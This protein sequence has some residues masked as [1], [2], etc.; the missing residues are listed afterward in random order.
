MPR[1]NLLIKKYYPLFLIFFGFLLMSFAAG[2]RLYNQRIL[3]FSSVPSQVEAKNLEKNIP[4][5]ITI[6]KVAIDVVVEV[7]TITDGV[8]Q[9]SNSGASFL[10][11]SAG[12]GEGGNI[13]IYGHNK[14]RIFGYIRNLK[15]AD[16]IELQDKKGNKHKY[17]VETIKIVEPDNIDYVQPK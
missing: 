4:T 17:K 14:A 3:S 8:W 13:V 15:K 2:F 11:I 5:R 1:K 16:V 10:D 6:S 9:I 12:I 7:S